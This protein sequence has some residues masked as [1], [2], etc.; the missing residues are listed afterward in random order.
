MENV[1][2]HLKENAQTVRLALHNHGVALAR[3]YLILVPIVVLGG[4]DLGVQR[5]VKIVIEIAA[6]RREPSDAPA[7]LR[8]IGVKLGQ[9]RAGNHYECCIALV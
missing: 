3:S 5:H 2:V 7:L 1:V 9:R 4:R 8:L 6:E